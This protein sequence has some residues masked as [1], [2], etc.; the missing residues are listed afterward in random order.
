M[1]WKPGGNWIQKQHLLSI[2]NTGLIIEE[3]IRRIMVSTK[4][5]VYF[6]GEEEL[7][8]A[9]IKDDQ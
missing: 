8:V 3:Y 4:D 5:N 7:A 6:Q 9:I 2:K 1:S